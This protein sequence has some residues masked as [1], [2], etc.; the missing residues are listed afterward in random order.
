[1]NERFTKK[2]LRKFGTVG[3]TIEITTIVILLCLACLLLPSISRIA[4]SGTISPR[5]EQ[6]LMGSTVNFA[7][8]MVGANFR[9]LPTMMSVV[10]LPSVAHIVIAVAFAGTISYML[11]AIWLGN[12]TVV[13]LIKY[14]HVHKRG[15]LILSGLIAI[16]AKVAII[17]VAFN[18]LGSLGVVPV[19]P[20]TA[21]MFGINQVWVALIGFGFAF[22]AIKVL[23]N[24]KLNDT[25]NENNLTSVQ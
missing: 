7:L 10:F 19:N 25:C 1:M 17:F 5:L 22:V 21:A 2:Q 15:S 6:F 9:G 24:K 11:P 12:I 18:V 20:F 4:P 3:L 16:A 23:Y 13:L 14:L 8:I